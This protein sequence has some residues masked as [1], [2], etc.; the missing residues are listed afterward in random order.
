MDGFRAKLFFFARPGLGVLD[1]L[2]EIFAQF[3]LD[4]CD[5]KCSLDSSDHFG[6]V[7]LGLGWLLKECSEVERVNRDAPFLFSLFRFQCILVW[8][9]L[10]PRFWRLNIHG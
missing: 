5:L 7:G 1:R 10:S 2:W 9:V 8:K 3:F 4:S 6:I